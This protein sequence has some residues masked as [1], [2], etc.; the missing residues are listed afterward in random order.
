MIRQSIPLPI[1]NC[2]YAPLK[3][4]LNY[5]TTTLFHFS[6]ALLT[7]TL[8]IITLIFFNSVKIKH[9][10]INKRISTGNI[11]NNTWVL[12]YFFVA[13]RA[14][15]EGLRL[16]LEIHLDKYLS[17]GLYC[18]VNILQ[19]ALILSLTL[20][21]DYQRRY[22]FTVT[23]PSRPN[24]R[25]GSAHS[26]T[27]LSINNIK[28]N[29]EKSPLLKKFEEIKKNVFQSELIVF[30]IFML[31]CWTF[32][33]LFMAQAQVDI[34][35]YIFLSFFGIQ[36]IPIFIL[37]Y[38]IVF[39]I[40]NG[41]SKWCKTLLCFGIILNIIVDMPLTIWN[42]LFDQTTCFIFDTFSIVDLTLV[43]YLL[44]TILLFIFMV[45]EFKRNSIESVDAAIRENQDQ[46]DFRRF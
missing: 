14:L 24:S 35:Y 15:C 30:I 4:F 45:L 31:L 34:F 44:S 13:L 46:F 9:S 39:T 43:L 21:L 23:L 20:S 18:L 22:R 17:V 1:A 26:G 10:E 2:S 27:H 40:D 7:I 12:F 32:F 5:S 29:T 42:I 38:I 33:Y 28:A 6:L 25:R 11:S 8:S 36:R 19:G 37:L 16:G 41:I 3:D